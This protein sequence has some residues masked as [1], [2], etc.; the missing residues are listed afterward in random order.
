MSAARRLLI[1]LAPAPLLAAPFLIVLITE[2]TQTPRPLDTAILG[3]GVL[4]AL[5]LLHLGLDHESTVYIAAGLFWYFFGV[6]LL[7]SLFGRPGRA[8]RIAFI[9]F[10]TAAILMAML[11]WSLRN[12]NPD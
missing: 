4:A 1:W 10:C 9:L 3:P 5:A 7:N 2:H 6:A 12:W 11:G 8:A